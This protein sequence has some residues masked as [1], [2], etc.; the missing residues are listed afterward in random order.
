MCV[1]ICVCV[2]SLIRSTTQNDKQM[3]VAVGEGNTMC[4]RLCSYGNSQRIL[5]VRYVQSLLIH[6]RLVN[7][8]VHT[9]PVTFTVNRVAVF[10]HQSSHLF[11]MLLLHQGFSICNKSGWNAV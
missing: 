2:E 6:T 1:R 7:T 5:E 3:D 4:V 11:L 10:P 8:S 9:T